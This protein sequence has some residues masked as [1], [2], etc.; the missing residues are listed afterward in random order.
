MLSAVF[1][2]ALAVLL[3]GSM[4][5]VAAFAASRTAVPAAASI[6]YLTLD[7][8]SAASGASGTDGPSSFAS[9]ANPANEPGN[10][11]SDPNAGSGSGSGSDTSAAPT[12]PDAAADVGQDLGTGGDSNTGGEDLEATDP[13]I[14]PDDP[15][16]NPDIDDPDPNADPSNASVPNDINSEEFRILANGDLNGKVVTFSSAMN[17]NMRLDVPRLSTS[18][19]TQL[20]LWS[21]NIGPNQRFCLEYAGGYYTI[22]NINS[23]LVLDVRF[24]R[25]ENNAGIIQW[26]DNGGDNQKWAFAD[27]GAGRYY[28]CSKLNLAY[29]IDVSK[30]LAANGQ[31]I[32]IWP[33]SDGK[34]NQQ[35]TIDVLNPTPGISPDTIYT[36]GSV[37]SGKLMDIYGGGFNNAAAAIIWPANSG[38]NQQFYFN[39]EVSSGYYT[40][41]SANSML[42]LDVETA[43]LN[44]GAK[45]IQWPQ[46]NGYNQR[47]VISTD[48]SGNYQ[49]ISAHNGMAIDVNGGLSVNGT[50]LIVWPSHGG[51]NQLWR[52]SARPLIYDGYY[53]ILSGADT[54]VDIEANNV[55]DGTRA[56]LFTYTGGFNQKFMI[57]S[58]GTDLYT[59]AAMNSDKLLTQPGGA[60]NS[61]GIYSNT[62]NNNQRWKAVP[63]GKGHIYL[64]NQAS[65]QYISVGNQAAAGTPLTMSASNT[66]AHGWRFM[67]TQLMPDGYYVFSSALN[68]DKV[69]GIANGSAQDRA[70]LE[71]S[72]FGDK[73]SQKFRVRN[74]SDGTALI[75]AMN[76]GKALDVYEGILGS[77][78]KVIQF[79][80]NQNAQ[81]QKWVIEYAGAGNVRF[82]SALQN[83]RAAMT[84]ASTSAVDGTIIMVTDKNGS[85]AQAFRPKWLSVPV[86]YGS[87]QRLNGI[88]VASHQPADIGDRVAYDFLIVKATQGTDYVNPY[89]HQQANSALWR[90]KKLG[91]YHFAEADSDPVAEARHFV[92]NS[93]AYI[94]R[95][96]L[97]LDF[98]AD[99]LNNGR[100]W[101]RSFMHEVKRQTGVSCGVYCAGYA[102][103]QYNIPGLCQDEGSIYWTANYSLGYQRIDG[104]RQDISPML[105]AP[106]YQYTSSGYLPGY[107]RALDFNLFY[108][109]PADWDYYATH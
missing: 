86:G 44:Q 32:I 26:P 8:S 94:G 104:Y 97:F 22:R 10:N 24:G 83:Q 1:S 25:A 100:E 9:P 75:I 72:S 63:S 35:F 66:A 14:N 20:N 80:A 21:A 16:P 38:M 46:N 70:L 107:D 60:S 87:Y 88:D 13:N 77:G 23:G 4:L 103:I 64:R 108:G 82:V 47:W 73:A 68:S 30:A 49:I 81:N 42:V 92:S 56:L 91:L 90:G 84:A 78:S 50:N 71:L 12:D 18:M 2:F 55:A 57:Q 48:D 39:Y 93:Q 58:I 5:P 54:Y 34:A 76:S 43:S 85:A 51:A 109:T 106:L 98:E 59:I 45:V 17:T 52:L 11:L 89:L 37:A 53:N 96:I 65:G 15:D 74:F 7:E 101:A 28:I 62:S 95:A 102:S 61:I 29:C 19:D 41:Q 33:R 40:I 31:E 67:P 99:A 105:P 79:S 27:A 36:V 6:S 69:L 3:T